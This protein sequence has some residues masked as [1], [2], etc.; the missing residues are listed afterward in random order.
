MGNVM[1][2]SGAG[3]GLGVTLCVDNV[4]LSSGAG[5]GFGQM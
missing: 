4:M 3:C 2:F 1:L 5:C